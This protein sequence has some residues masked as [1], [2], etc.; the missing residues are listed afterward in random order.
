MLKAP[1]YTLAMFEEAVKKTRLMVFDIIQHEK[2]TLTSVADPMNNHALSKLDVVLHTLDRVRNLKKAVE[3]YHKLQPVHSI[4]KEPFSEFVNSLSIPLTDLVNISTEEQNNT[5][6]M[7]YKRV[8]DTI[9][10][11]GGISDRLKIIKRWLQSSEHC[12]QYQSTK[13]HPDLIDYIVQMQTHLDKVHFYL[14]QATDEQRHACFAKPGYIS[15][16]IS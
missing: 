3:L 13:L 12:G 10:N 1:V 2:T 15:S 8:F 16:F 5:N 14:M 6:R 9:G 7:H 11:I 4:G